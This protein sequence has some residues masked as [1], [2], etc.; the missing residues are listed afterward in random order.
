MYIVQK[1][2]GSFMSLSNKKKLFEKLAKIAKKILLLHAHMHIY[3]I[4]IHYF[5]MP[6]C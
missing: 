4:Y 1:I 6:N 2:I 3:V 5:H